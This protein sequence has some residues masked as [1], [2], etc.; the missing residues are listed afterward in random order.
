VPT[1][2]RYPARIVP[3]QQFELT[4]EWVNR[5]VGRAMRD[6]TL[7][8]SLADAD[9]KTVATADAG[10]L[11]TDKWVKGQTYRVRCAATFDDAK[12]GTYTLRIAV[13]DPKS[14]AAIQLPLK[15]GADGSYAIGAVEVGPR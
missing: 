3:K 5:G 9:G 14:A 11:G 13:V 6:Y 15:D 8:L 7:R 2:L 12:P 4:S 10:P 1:K